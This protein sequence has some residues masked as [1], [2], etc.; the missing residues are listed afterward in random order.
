MGAAKETRLTDRQKNIGK[1]A[2]RIHENDKMLLLKVLRNEGFTYQQYAVACAEALL[3]GDRECFEIMKTW[4]QFNEIPKEDIDKF[5]LSARERA[6][7]QKD[8]E[9][10]RKD[11]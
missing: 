9:D 3:R 11:E 1:L 4:K 5:T 8:L 10:M 2:F 7:I 6:Q